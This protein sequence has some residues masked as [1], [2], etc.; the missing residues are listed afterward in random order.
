MR[1]AEGQHH[2]GVCVCV[3]VCVPKDLSAP[4]LQAL[5]SPQFILKAHFIASVE[6]AIIRAGATKEQATKACV[7]V[8]RALSCAKPPP[9]NTLPGEP[10]AEAGH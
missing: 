2:H 1:V 10:T 8:V 5:S 9:S 3:C 7:S 6:A 4:Q